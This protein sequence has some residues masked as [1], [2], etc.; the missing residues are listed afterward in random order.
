MSLEK[1]KIVILALYQEIGWGWPIFL[2]RCTRRSAGIF[3]KTHWSKSKGSESGFVRR[4]AFASA[5]YLELQ[6]KPGE[7][8]AFEI[9]DRILIQIVCNEQWQYYRSLNP[10]SLSSMKLLMAFHNLMDEQGAP[11]FNTRK[12]IERG[13]NKCHFVIERCIFHDFFAETGVPELAGLFCKVDQVFF[14]DA[15]PA[16]NFHRNGS[17]ENTLACGHDRCEFVLELRER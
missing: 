8:R 5:M 6:K 9:M 4:L 11:R 16:F 14:P 15:F 12:Y 10:A 17:W 2:L 7:K 3:S 13:E 1:L